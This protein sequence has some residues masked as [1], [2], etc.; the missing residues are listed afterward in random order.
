MLTVKHIRSDGA[1]TTDHADRAIFYPNVEAPD[2]INSP[3]P[4][5]GGCV[6]VVPPSGPHFGWHSGVVYV[7]N[8]NGAT[9]A[10]YDLGPAEK[11]G[12]PPAA[13]IA[14]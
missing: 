2:Q 14:A 12:L 9:V 11:F 3:C 4:H 7:M 13:A 1:E 8:A 5:W 6:T 10:K